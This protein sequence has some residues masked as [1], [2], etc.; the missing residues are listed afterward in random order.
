MSVFVSVFVFVF[1]SVFVSVF[2]SVYVF[3]FESTFVCQGRTKSVKVGGI[4]CRLHRCAVSS[5]MNTKQLQ[6]G[7]V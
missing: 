4:E 6:C 5:P 2:V 3:V 1:K 7:A